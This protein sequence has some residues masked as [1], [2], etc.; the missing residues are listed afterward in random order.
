MTLE[1]PY[2]RSAAAVSTASLL[3]AILLAAPSANA[4]GVCEKGYRDT[5]QAER[6]TIT[7]TLEAVRASLPQAPDGWIIGGYEEISALEKTCSDADDTPWGYNFTRIFNRVDDA[8]QRD[9]A[10]AAESAKLQASMAARQPRMDALMARIGELGAAL[11]AAAQKGD[12]ARI[13]AINREIAQV[14]TEVESVLNEGSDQAQYEA[15]AA[16]QM[17]DR[18]IEIA[19]AVNPSSVWSNDLESTAAPAGAHAAFRGQT[20]DGGV[21]TGHMLVLLG[22][23][24][25]REDGGLELVKRG[26]ASSAAAHGIAVNVTADPARLDAVLSTIAFGDLAALVR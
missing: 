14:Q 2:S 15:I 26:S 8:E 17:Q 12:Q 23:W 21:T 16:I 3:V 25:P 18:T 9:Q 5:T 4:D 10:L 24:R 22:G 11:G 13:D 7:S 6:Q 1:H 20:A 19:I